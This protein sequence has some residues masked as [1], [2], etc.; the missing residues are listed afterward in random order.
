MPHQ[1]I[2]RREESESLRGCEPSPGARGLL[3]A[4]GDTRLLFS[5]GAHE[6]VR[7]TRPR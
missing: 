4:S 3:G 2:R 7:P 5:A 6:C 1:P